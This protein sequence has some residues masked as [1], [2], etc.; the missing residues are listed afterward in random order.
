MHTS[1]EPIYIHTVKS[2]PRQSC[3]YM[4]Q[5]THYLLAVKPGHIDFII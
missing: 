3:V 4:A 2:T 5:Q 1:I